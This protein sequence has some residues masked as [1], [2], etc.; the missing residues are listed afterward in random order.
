VKDNYKEPKTTMEIEAPRK[1]KRRIVLE[2]EMCPT[3][4]ICGEVKVHVSGTIAVPVEQPPHTVV[5][6]YQPMPKNIAAPKKRYP[7]EHPKEG[8][9][10]NTGEMDQRNTHW[11][12][13]KNL[14]GEPEG[15]K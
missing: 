8:K 3:T 1:W 5:S 15:A 6:Q 10:S 7:S 13:T 11:K 4:L 12:R 9:R 14:K 2:A